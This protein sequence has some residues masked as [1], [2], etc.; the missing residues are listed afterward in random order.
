MAMLGFDE[1]KGDRS[2]SR[3]LED[4]KTCIDAPIAFQKRSDDKMWQNGKA[5]LRN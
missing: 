3:G 1:N 4:A 5:L 2:A